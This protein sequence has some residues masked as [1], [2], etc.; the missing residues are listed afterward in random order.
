MT[1]VNTSPSSSANGNNISVS[2]NQ[3]QRHIYLSAMGITVWQQRD[4]NHESSYHDNVGK[5]VE[6]GPHNVSKLTTNISKKPS[7]QP[8]AQPTS[9]NP[10]PFSKSPKTETQTVPIDY[11]TL[12]WSDLKATVATCQQCVL[13]KERNQ[14]I[15]GQGNHHASLMIIGH[16]PAD[17][18]DRQGL[19]FAGKTA[20]LLTNM[21]NSINI[22]TQNVYLTNLIKCRPPNNRPPYKKELKQCYG[23]IEQQIK[24]IQPDLILVVGRVAA[25]QLLRSTNSLAQ[26]RNKI[27]RL[28]PSNTPLIT[29]YH[30]AYLLRQ[31]GAKAKAWK[32]LQQVQEQLL[33]INKRRKPSTDAYTTP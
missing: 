23:F 30:P 1:Y 25:Q 26:L 2:M 27:H 20:Q 11:A 6:N 16:A 15:T 22:K 31:T 32:D 29:T 12:D 13:A 10:P 19:P 33:S 4:K 9:K 7:F 14:A 21:L 28:E 24:L 8:T 17:D 3:Q 18:E 5:I